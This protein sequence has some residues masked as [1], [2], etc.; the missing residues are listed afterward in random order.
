MLVNAG[1]TIAA[2]SAEL[3]GRGNGGGNR[4]DGMARRRGSKSER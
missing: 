2:Q 4:F 3:L 1:V